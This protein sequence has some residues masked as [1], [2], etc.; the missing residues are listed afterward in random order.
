M[1][2]NHK[3]DCRNVRCDK[4]CW[5]CRQKIICCIIYYYV[6]HNKGKRTATTNIITYLAQK[7]DVYHVNKKYVRLV[8]KHNEKIIKKLLQKII[9]VQT[10][11]ICEKLKVSLNTKMKGGNGFFIK[12]TN[13]KNVEIDRITIYMETNISYIDGG[14]LT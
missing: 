12:L 4:I 10:D 5:M 13:C 2:K 8:Y 14:E 3:G 11:N 6:V 1:C 7:L 9:K